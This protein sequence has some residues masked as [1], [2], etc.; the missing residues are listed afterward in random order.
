[1]TEVQTSCGH[2]TPPLHGW[3]GNYQSTLL[4]STVTFQCDSGWSPSEQFSTTCMGT[5]HLEWVPDPGNHTC[6]GMYHVAWYI[7]LPHQKP[8]LRGQILPLLNSKIQL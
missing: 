3:L 8:L 7:Y 2:P 6:S 5:D 4:N 1:M